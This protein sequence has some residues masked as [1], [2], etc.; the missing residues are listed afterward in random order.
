MNIFS[1]DNPFFRFVGR[2]VDLV[3]INI[4]TL[5]CMIPV[6]T[7]GAALCGMY[8]VLLKINM[9]EEGTITKTFFI[10]FKNS[11]KKATIVWIPS[12]FI[13]VI[14]AA[15]FYLLNNGV[16]NDYG[17]LYIPVGVSI[18]ILLAII[19]MFWQFYFSLLSR[20]DNDVAGTIRNA[21]LLML[22]FFPSAISILVILAL[23]I[24]L[25][26]ISNYFLFFWVLYGFSLPG[27]F[28]S[29]ILAKVYRR[30][31]ESASNNVTV[32]SDEEIE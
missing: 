13:A 24:A 28:A 9:N 2:L 6:V 16:L 5:I 17:K 7:G 19:L 25:M 14:L 1:M 30:S 11:F 27:F 21:L 29:M 12:F 20:Y 3:W 23:P 8:R 10:E 4:L 26:T 22:A 31:E 32:K 15:N 18:G